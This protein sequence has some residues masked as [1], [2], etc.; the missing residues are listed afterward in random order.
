VSITRQSAASALATFR[1]WATGRQFDSSASPGTNDVRRADRERRAAASSIAAIVARFLSL[2]LSFL[3][4]PLTIGYLGIERY[5]MLAALTGLMSMLVFADLGLSNGLMNIVSDANGKDDKSAAA[6]AVSSGF[7]M[8][9]FVAIVVAAV[10]VLGFPYVDWAQLLGVKTASAVAD[11]GPTAVVLLTLF[12]IGLP[13]GTI[14]RIRLAYQEGFLNAT[15]AIGAALLSLAALILVIVAGGGLPL[16][17]LAISLPPV[18]ALAINGLFLLRRRPWLMPRFRR[19]QR[20]MAV[21]LARLGFLFFVLQLAVAVAYQSDVVVA[22]A[23]LGAGAAATYAVTLKVFLLVPSL[24]AMFLVT[25]WP[26][27]TEALARHDGAWIRRT[28]RRSIWIALGATG[29]ASLVL[30]IAGSW[31]I[32]T[33]TRN[34]VDPPFELLVGA[35]LWAVVS[36]GFNAVAML[37]NAASV[38][39][40]QVVAAVSMA[41]LSITLSIALANTIGLAGIIW[42]TLLAYILVSAL[43]VCIYLPRV[44]RQFGI[45]ETGAR[46]VA[47]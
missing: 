25:L 8:L 11:A 22:A 31:F 26:A 44:L 16:V 19:F 14:E 35:A 24:V 36:T 38:M 46:E 29:V 45:A 4:V 1:R 3:V 23:V 10:F 6:I 33:W 30:V 47:R 2:A 18:L 9:A 42:G 32:R 7:F 15:A 21:R 28:L 5:G 37:L 20:P 43:P 40:F 39:A 12:V 41:A 13:L 34:A 17:V 27:Y